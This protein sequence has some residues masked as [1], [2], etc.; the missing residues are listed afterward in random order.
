[1]K[2]AFSKPHFASL[3]LA[4]LFAYAGI[5]ASQS[6]QSMQS[7][8]EIVLAAS[9]HAVELTAKPVQVKLVSEKT[10][11]ST[12]LG[13]I[14]ESLP[15]SRSVYLELTGLHAVEQPG[16]LFHLYLDLPEDV[17]PKPANA[18][19]IGSINFY[20]AVPGPDAPKGKPT[21][22]I[23]IDITAVVRKLRSSHKLASVS[24]ITVMATHPLES[25]S[26]PMIEHIAMIIK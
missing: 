2:Y 13:Q 9:A 1:M 19:H 6:A 3:T 24:T 17:T 20:N 26:R 21:L 10:G 12:S 14:L 16:T 22:P 23:S 5:F 25:G 8:K 11:K 7:S 15:S 4:L 18:W